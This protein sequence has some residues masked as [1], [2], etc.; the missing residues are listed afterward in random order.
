MKLLL[1]LW[2]I[3]LIEGSEY[4]YVWPFTITYIGKM[5]KM[6]YYLLYC[7]SHRISP[8]C[9]WYYV[10]GITYHKSVVRAFLWACNFQIVWVSGISYCKS[11]LE[12]RLQ[13]QLKMQTLVTLTGQFTDYGIH[14]TVEACESLVSLDVL[15]KRH[16][17]YI[18][19]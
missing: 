16:C 11:K 19:H 3:L 9:N 6:L 18:V 4:K 8:K 2:G 7:H 15:L 14:V 1:L 10:H 13:N 12:F 17:I 5:Y